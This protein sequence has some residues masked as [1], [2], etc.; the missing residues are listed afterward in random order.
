MN[1]A[2]QER[3]S[4]A[5]GAGAD[6]APAGIES[7]T[8]SIGMKLVWIPAGEFIMGLPDEGKDRNDPVSGVPPE[9]PPHRVRIT[10]GLPWRL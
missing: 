3:P 2:V 8:T 9:V 7:I 1:C 6:P 10:K 5:A 4:P